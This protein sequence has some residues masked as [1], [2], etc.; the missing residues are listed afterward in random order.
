MGRIAVPGS[1]ILK[2]PP[3]FEELGL[4]LFQLWATRNRPERLFPIRE[5][6]Q[7]RSITVK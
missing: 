5:I 1:A 6:I 3:P 2:V 7:V 4:E